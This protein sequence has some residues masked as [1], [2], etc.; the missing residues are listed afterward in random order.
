ML[1]LWDIDATLVTTTRSGVRALM[2]AGQELYGPGFTT[3][4][5]DF[6]GR[7]DPLIIG[8]LLRLNGQPAGEESRMADGYRRHLTT[9]LAQPGIAKTLPGVNALVDRFADDD[10]VTQ[11]LL[12]GNYE[13]TGLMKIRAAGLDP[14]DFPVRAWGN[15]SP[16]DPPKREHLVPVAL[17]RYRGLTD[18]NVP[19]H[20]VTIVGD[21]PHDI[22]CAKAH[23]CRSVA[24]A[25][26][27]YTLEQLASHAPDLLVPTLADTAHVG[28]WIA[29][30][31]R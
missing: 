3:E 4:G 2:L 21:T 29:S 18:R 5:V 13:Q 31:A 30:A 28:D 19:A 20:H 22:R 24:V 10:A 12:T 23:G 9:L 16:I 25:T 17:N 11:G 14:D 8:D 7:L 26:G 1:I 15:E 6:G 27:Q